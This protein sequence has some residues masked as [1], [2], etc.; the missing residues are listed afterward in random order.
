MYIYIYVS[1]YMC[2]C[3]YIYVYIY[4][5]L[6]ILITYIWYCYI[7]GG[8]FIDGLGV[9]R[10]GGYSLSHLLLQHQP[11]CN[12]I[13]GAYTIRVQGLHSL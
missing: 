1:A 13:A 10:Q 3:I 2:I 7:M 6:Y 4:I 5:C 8:T 11:G 9:H 12:G